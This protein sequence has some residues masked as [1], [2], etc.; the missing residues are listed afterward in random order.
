MHFAGMLWPWAAVLSVP[1]SHTFQRNSSLPTWKAKPVHSR[2]AGSVEQNQNCIEE[3]TKLESR[4][5]NLENKGWK[6]IAFKEAPAPLGFTEPSLADH[7]FCFFYPCLKVLA[8]AIRWIIYLRWNLQ[9]IWCDCDSDKNQK[10][11]FYA[12]IWANV[13]K[14]INNIHFLYLSCFSSDWF[15][16]SSAG[17]HF[18]DSTAKCNRYYQEKKKA[19]EAVYQSLS[20][21]NWV[22]TTANNKMCQCQ[23][24]KEDAFTR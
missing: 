7:K 10:G 12:D 4:K 15:I 13:I 9:A 22:S 5:Q 3:I 23:Q 14:T 6:D 24:L 17:L 16:L 19:I 1:P 21:F 18:L 8:K 11:T 2:G 20:C